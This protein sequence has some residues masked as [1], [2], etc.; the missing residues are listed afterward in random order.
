MRDTILMIL[1]LAIPALA[2]GAD[3]NTDDEQIR[4][5][6]KELKPLQKI[7]YSWPVPF[8]K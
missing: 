1:L 8:K 4:T 3:A 6:L 5:W 2:V 7:H